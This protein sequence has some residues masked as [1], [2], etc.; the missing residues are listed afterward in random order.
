MSRYGVILKSISLIL[1]ILF[2]I[3][4]NIDTKSILDEELDVYKNMQENSNQSQLLNE[5]TVS[6]EDYNS[7]TDISTT[8]PSIPLTHTFARIFASFWIIILAIGLGITG[9]IIAPRKLP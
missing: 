4:I 2:F 6:E 9:R 5:T 3:A 8:K 1:I 7:G